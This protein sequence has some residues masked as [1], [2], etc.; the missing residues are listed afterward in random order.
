MVSV[1]GGDRNVP[2]LLSR[3]RIATL[4]GSILVGLCTG[5]NYVCTT[6]ICSLL[7]HL[8]FLT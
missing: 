4:L 1:K 7:E 5:T 6:F 2:I 8:S 3:P